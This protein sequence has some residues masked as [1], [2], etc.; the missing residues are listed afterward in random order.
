M[1]VV[2]MLIPK[3]DERDEDIFKKYVMTKGARIYEDE[4]DTEPI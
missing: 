2:D 3:G 4:D 1:C